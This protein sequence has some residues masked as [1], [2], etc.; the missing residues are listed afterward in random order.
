MSMFAEGDLVVRDRLDAC[1]ADR[2]V[3]LAVDGPWLWVRRDGIGEPQTWTV[4]SV[5]LVER[6]KP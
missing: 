6:A 4:T 2:A 5:S 3:V 1:T